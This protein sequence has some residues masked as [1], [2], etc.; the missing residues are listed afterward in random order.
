MKKSKKVV[1]DEIDRWK[2]VLRGKIYCSPACGGGVQFGC[3]KWAHDAAV[4]NAAKLAARMGPE[5]TP[6][7]WEN[8]GWHYEAV[9]KGGYLKVSE[10]S[11]RSGGGWHAYLGEPGSG[12]RWTAFSTKSP[13]DVVALVRAQ[14]AESIAEQLAMYFESS[15]AEAAIV[16]KVLRR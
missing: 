4:R 11:Q 16:L 10:S 1:E 12:G 6:R 3:T 5:W 13:E 14:A 8:L 9:G 15:V 2:P 7:V